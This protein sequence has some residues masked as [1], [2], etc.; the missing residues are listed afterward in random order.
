MCLS[1]VF[2]VRLA[3]RRVGWEALLAEQQEAQRNEQ[4]EAEQ[5]EHAEWALAPRIVGK[6]Q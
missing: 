2:V 1:Q 3:R 5:A 6:H 4:A